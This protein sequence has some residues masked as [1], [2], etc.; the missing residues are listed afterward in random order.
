M[1]WTICNNTVYAKKVIRC[2]LL[3]LYNLIICKSYSKAKKTWQ[4]I[5]I[6]IYICKM[7]NTFYKDY[8]EK[9]ITISWL[10]NSIPPVANLVKP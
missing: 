8:L 1:K 7:I 6:V 4:P 2:Q 9:P 10:I 3:E 5:L